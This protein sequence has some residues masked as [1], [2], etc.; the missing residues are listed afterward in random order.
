M[1]LTPTLVAGAVLRAPRLNAEDRGR[2]APA[3][4]VLT[5]CLL[6]WST[7]ETLLFIALTG[8]GEVAPF[9]ET[10]QLVMNELSDKL[11]DALQTVRVDLGVEDAITKY[12]A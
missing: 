1:E 3:M 5:G 12:L 7:S 8:G 4:A 6:G 10:D 11:Y 9:T 2:V